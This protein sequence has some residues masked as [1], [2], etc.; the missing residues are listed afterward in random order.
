MK[1][2]HTPGPW[3]ISKTI[4]D[5]SI[6]AEA[7]DNLDIAA[8]YQKS[9]AIDHEEAR[10]NTDIIAASPE[11]VEALE[12]IVAAINGEFDNPSLMK[13]GALYADREDSIKEIAIQALHK[14]NIYL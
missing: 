3:K 10:A 4:N 6:Y 11:L 2:K 7:N 5:F 12:A 8:V 1:K 13:F 14:A 9:R